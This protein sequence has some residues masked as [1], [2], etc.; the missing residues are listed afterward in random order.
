MFTGKGYGV[1]KRSQKLLRNSRIKENK[2][3]D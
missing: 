1:R 2:I 3:N